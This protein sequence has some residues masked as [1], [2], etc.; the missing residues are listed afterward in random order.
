MDRVTV[1]VNYR[2]SR[3]NRDDTQAIHMGY[4]VDG[5]LHA[6]IYREV[7]A[8][9]FE[10]QFV[11]DVVNNIISSTETHRRNENRPNNNPPP[12]NDGDPPPTNP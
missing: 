10:Y 5:V 11:D 7:D 6:I 8:L 1:I 2:S 3:V 9:C 4:E 12:R